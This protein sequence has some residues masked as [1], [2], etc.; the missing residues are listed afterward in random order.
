PRRMFPPCQVS[1]SG[2][3]A[4]SKYLMLI[5][6]IPVDSFRYKWQDQQWEASG[7]AEPH[8]PDRVYIHPDSPAPGSHWMRQTVSFHRLKLT[9]NTLDQHGHII[10]HSMHRYQLRLH[11]VQ[12]RDV[13]SPTWSACSS[14]TFPETQF[15]GVTAYQ[16]QK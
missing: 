16:N 9:N 12:A 3:R 11:V 6:F 13:F 14:F 7:K 10:L 15:M 1:V 5:D 8:L 2:L 4:D